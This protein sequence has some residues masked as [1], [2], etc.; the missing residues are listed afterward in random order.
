MSKSIL[1]IDTPESCAYCEIRFDDIYSNWCPYNNP[2]VDGVY[3]YVKQRTKPD[4]CPL[5]P[6]PEKIEGYDSIKRQWG[7][8][9][10]GWNH[11]IDSILG[12]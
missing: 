10:D 2:E 8:Y 12:E 11:C 7:E 9:E 6:L 3:K 5:R 1:V 4:W